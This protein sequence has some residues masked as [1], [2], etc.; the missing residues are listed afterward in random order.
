MKNGLTDSAPM[1]P[2]HPVLSDRPEIQTFKNAGVNS[3]GI[4][5]GIEQRYL[6]ILFVTG[7]NEDPECRSELLSCQGDIRIRT[8]HEASLSQGSR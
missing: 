7:L 6:F 1:G 3:R 4:R 2:R 5:A 8:R